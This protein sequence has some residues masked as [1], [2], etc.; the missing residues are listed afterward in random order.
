MLEWYLKHERYLSFGFTYFTV[1]CI[2]SRY[3][4]WAKVTLDFQLPWLVLYC[5]RTET[6]TEMQVISSTSESTRVLILNT[7]RP[8]LTPSQIL[9]L[10]PVRPRLRKWPNLTLSVDRTARQKHENSCYTEANQQWIGS[11]PADR[12]DRLIKSN[13]KTGFSSVYPPLNPRVN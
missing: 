8:V 2:K 7:S 1:N 3:N 4:F 11:F 10:V 13:S 12:C 5:F 9:S 6:S